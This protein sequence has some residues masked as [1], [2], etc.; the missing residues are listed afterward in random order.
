MLPREIIPPK[1]HPGKPDKENCERQRYVSHPK[2]R[3]NNEG[4]PRKRLRKTAL[5][6]T[7]SVAT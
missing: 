7:I 2:K 3:L 1:I 5:K 6:D 4:G